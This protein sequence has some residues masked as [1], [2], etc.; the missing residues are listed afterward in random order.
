MTK[1]NDNRSTARPPIT[2]EER[3]RPDRRVKRWGGEN[4]LQSAE[5]L[6]P[7]A[8]RMSSIVNRGG[9]VKHLVFL[10]LGVVL[11]AACATAEQV[12][13]LVGT[14]TGVDSAGIRM[15]FVFEADGKGLWMVEL[16]EMTD[17]TKVDW[18]ADMETAPHHLD[19]AHFDHGPLAGAALYG[20]FEFSGPDTFRLDLEPGPPGAGDRAPRP[21]EF[22]G[23]TVEFSRVKQ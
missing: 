4:R 21:T 9:A 8:H 13:S 10:G 23:E 16:P 1:G 12:P 7:I 15:S 19:L 11:V 20:I 14:W 3:N 18:V 22:T 6:M 2:G 5:C 17:T